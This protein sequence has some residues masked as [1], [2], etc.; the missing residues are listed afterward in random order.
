[1]RGSDNFGAVSILVLPL[2]DKSMTN[3]L[4]GLIKSEFMIFH[5]PLEGFVGN[6]EEILKWINNFKLFNLYKSNFRN[7]SLIL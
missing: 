7:K 3:E 5:F 2:F 6:K 1:M 4:L